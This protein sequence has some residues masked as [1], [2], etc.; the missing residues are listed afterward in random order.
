MSGIRVIAGTAKGRK[1]KLVPGDTTR[2]I[3]DRVKESLFN[4]LGTEIRGATML[5][6]F[7][8][9]GSVGI[10]ALS[11][12]AAFV[13]FLDLAPKA[14]QTIHD[15]LTT[16][17]VAQKA[18][19]L[20]LDAFKHLERTP[21][22]LFDYIY[23]APPQYKNLWLHALEALDTHPAWLTEDGW[24]IVQIDPREYIEKTLQNLIEFDQRRYGNTLLVFYKV[25]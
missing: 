20:R 17:Q 6:L 25:K 22:K 14:I 21:D 12:G 23:I 4:I 13:R 15:N 24:V 1:L 7:A 9:T 10:E 2:P 19:V 18:E 11:R 16:A 3:T 8:G 5:D